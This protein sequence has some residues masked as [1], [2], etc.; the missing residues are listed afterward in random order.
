MSVPI[1]WQSVEVQLIL[2]GAGSVM[3]PPA[4]YA[5][6]TMPVL[7]NGAAMVGNMPGSAQQVLQFGSGNLMHAHS[8]SYSTG[9]SF[10]ITMLG[11]LELLPCLG[12]L[13]HPT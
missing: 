5:A 10:G 2:C 7:P 11:K 6:S 13:L 9:E 4:L 3:S 8:T 12:L 1:E